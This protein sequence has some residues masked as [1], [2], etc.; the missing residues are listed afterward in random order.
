MVVEYEGGP[1]NT[2]LL[3]ATASRMLSCLFYIELI[4]IP[5]FYSVPEMA[6]IRLSCRLPPGPPLMHLVSELRRG[7]ALLHYR[8]DGDACVEELI[9]PVVLTRCRKGGAFYKV[10]GMEV[11]SMAS[12]LDVKIETRTGLNSISNCPYELRK[13]LRD[14]KLDCVFGRDDHRSDGQVSDEM[15]SEEIEKLC[16]TLGEIVRTR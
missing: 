10:L 4:T 7:R 2:R 8:G 15:M 1:I 16:D 11:T 14:Q 6:S 5:T 12:A 3:R 13:L 9:T